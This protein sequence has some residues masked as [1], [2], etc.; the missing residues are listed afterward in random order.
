ML[1][2]RSALMKRHA[3]AL[4][5][6][7]LIA[8]SAAP[9]QQASAPFQVAETG[10]AY[11]RLAD[12]IKAIGDKQ[13]TILIAPG[14]YKECAVQ[15]AGH[16][17]FKAKVAGLA[18]FDGG[19]CED[20]AALVLR[21]RSSAV[22]GLVFQNMKV[23]DGNGAG[24]RIER[25]NLAVTRSVFRNSEQGILAAP[26]PTGE[27]IVDQSTFSKLGRCD[28]DLACAHSIYVGD[29][30]ALTVTRSRFERGSGGHYVK[31]RAARAIIQNNAFDDTRG[32]ATN[33]MIDLP[34]GAT[35]MI[36][37]NIFVQGEDKDNPDAFITIAAEERK[38]SSAGLAVSGNDASIAPGV[39]RSSAF[40]ADWSGDPITLGANRLGR[41]LKP[42]VKR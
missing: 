22:D 17:V 16:I 18:I 14:T 7:S 27:I 31:S 5:T 41:G 3:F 32:T 6:A 15:Q 30:G 28:R 20:K 39:A 36:S 21:G 12:A 34:N 10:Q 25:G 2:Q 40:L 8:T 37:G 35:G 1:I 33:Y 38:R 4:L 11:G 24:I 19:I 26:D 29:Y 23:P 13:G 42:F 9:A